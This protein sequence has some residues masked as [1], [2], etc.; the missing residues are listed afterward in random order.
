[1]DTNLS[2]A[3]D[4]RRYLAER[5]RNDWDWPPL[6]LPPPPANAVVPPA[7]H[8]AAAAAAAADA[9]YCSATGASEDELRGVTEFRERYYGSTDDDNDDAPSDED[10]EE[11]EE[12]RRGEDA[13]AAAAAAAAAVAGHDDAVVTPGVRAREGSGSGGKEYRFDSPEHVGPRVAAERAARRKR[14]RRRALEEEMRWNEGMAVFVRRRDRWTG[15]AS[16]RKYARRRSRAS[17][18]MDPVEVEARKVV[19]RMLEETAVVEEREEEVVDAVVGEGEDVPH[20]ENGGVEH[21]QSGDDALA[22]N[23]E[24][25]AAAAAADGENGN[26]AQAAQEGGEQEGKGKVVRRKSVININIPASEEPLV[27]LAPPLLPNNAIRQS[28]TPKVYSDIY[29]KIVIS[30]QTPKV[31]I[32]LSHMTRA[33][34][35]GW[36]DDGEWPPRPGPADPLMGR[37]KVAAAG[38][39]VGTLAAVLGGGDGGAKGASGS[40]AVGHHGEFLA[41]HPHL[42]KGVESVKK[43]FRLSGGHHGHSNPGAGLAQDG[44]PPTN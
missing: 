9:E 16:V 6:P 19:V 38:G 22:P 41:H 13:A 1:M 39:R 10:E 34:V 11:G 8:A 18:D 37:K 27:P 30:G 12:G 42:Q 40:G 7:E 44:H 2:A 26:G 4:A 15:A 31:P 36:K 17:E 21:G 28:V 23:G 5:V 25:T 29:A 24:E 32:N 14:R 33:L 20:G 35:Q 43:V 3:R